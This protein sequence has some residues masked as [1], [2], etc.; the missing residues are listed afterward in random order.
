MLGPIL[1]SSSSGRD[2]DRCERSS[3]DAA[4]PNLSS[5][6][7][8]AGRTSARSPTAFT[9]R[10]SKTFGV[11][12]DDRFQLIHQHERDELI[13][14]K[15]YLD[16]HRTDDLAMINIIAGDWRDTSKKKALYQS[17]ARRLAADP[18][19]RPED[20]IIVLSP[21][22]RDEW[23]FGNGLASYVEDGDAA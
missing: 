19:L 1:P 2:I 21:N 16:I 9:K 15:D 22:A 7:Q 14:D 20:V 18:G 4:R 10:W 5:Q 8:A 12:V 3:C 13:Y 11:P 6:G 17:I 23:S